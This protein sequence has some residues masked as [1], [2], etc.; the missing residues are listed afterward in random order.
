VLGIA[1][2]V[3]DAPHAF[4]FEGVAADD[5]TFTQI[6]NHQSDR[7]GR[8]GQTVG[9]TNTLDAAVGGELDKDEVGASVMGWWVGNDKGFEVGDFHSGLLKYNDIT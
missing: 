7:A 9:F 5:V 4:N 2:G 1:A 3:N 8:E 6:L